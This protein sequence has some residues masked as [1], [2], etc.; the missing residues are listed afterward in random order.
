MLGRLNQNRFPSQNPRYSEN[1]NEAIWDV[2]KMNSVSNNALAADDINNHAWIDTE[3]AQPFN[4]KDLARKAK[5]LIVV[6]GHSVTVSG[7]LEDAGIDES[8]W[9]LL[10]YQ[11]GQGLPQAIHA[12]IQA[13]I[14]EAHK[15]SSALLIFSGEE[16]R[17]VSGPQ[18]EA[19]AYYHVADLIRATEG[20]MQKC[21]GSF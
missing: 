3:H 21:G 13:G 6:A 5:H 14:E 11:K 17:A 7:H 19:Q 16:T 2:L 4:D 20:E 15:D 10:R 8:D 12:H 18:T 9:L 1:R